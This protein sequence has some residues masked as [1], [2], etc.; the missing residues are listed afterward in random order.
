[1]TRD[2]PKSANTMDKKVRGTTRRTSKGL[3][4]FG[5][6]VR[7]DVP[8]AFRSGVQSIGKS[9]GKVRKSTAK[10][11]R[12]V[13]TDVLNGGLI[14]AFNKIAR[15][16]DSDTMKRLSEIGRASCRERG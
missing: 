6:V 5:G 1:M 2:L 15:F 9:W 14:K 8:K 4:S 7:S 10:P 11:I 16:T 12:Y 13:I 3:H